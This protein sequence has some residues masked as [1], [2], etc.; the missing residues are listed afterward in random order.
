LLGVVEELKYEVNGLLT[1]QNEAGFMDDVTGET[2]S[3]YL[4]ILEHKLL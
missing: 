1:L 2:M 3:R 4:Q